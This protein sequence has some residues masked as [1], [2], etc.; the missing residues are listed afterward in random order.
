M[1]GVATLL[2][3]LSVIMA[4]SGELLCLWYSTYVGEV[5]N[6]LMFIK[7]NTRI[8]DLLVRMHKLSIALAF[9]AVFM[10]IGKAFVFSVFFGAR[11][12]S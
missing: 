2:L 6:S 5:K 11:S 10:H 12:A 8:G 9:V 3:L 7:Y 1:N 4:I